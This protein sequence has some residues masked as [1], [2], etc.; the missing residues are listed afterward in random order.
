MT[1]LQRIRIFFGIDTEADRR[2]RHVDMLNKVNDAINEMDRREADPDKT[3]VQRRR[4]R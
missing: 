3:P 2:A 1:W 4:R